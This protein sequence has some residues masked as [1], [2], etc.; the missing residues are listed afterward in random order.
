MAS[1]LNLAITVA[2]FG[3]TLLHIRLSRSYRA[4]WQSSQAE[5]NRYRDTVRWASL[6]LAD[7]PEAMAALTWV[8]EQSEGGIY[9]PQT[10]NELRDQMKAGRQAYI[11]WVASH[12]AAKPAGAT[13]WCFKCNAHK[14]LDQFTPAAPDCPTRDG[15]NYGCNTCSAGLPKLRRCPET[16]RMYN[17]ADT[18]VMC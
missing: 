13:R 15:Y 18:P 8:R 17:P 12:V 4:R 6:R 3:M 1:W 14:P 2:L 7:Y 10:I 11:E 9:Q 5:A 16:R